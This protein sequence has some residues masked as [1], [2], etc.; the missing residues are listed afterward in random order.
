MRT[1]KKFLLAAA[2]AG[3]MTMGACDVDQTRDGELPDVDVDVEEGQMPAYD[4]DGPEVEIGADQ[5][6]IVVTTPD[7]DVDVPDDDTLGTRY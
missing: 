4:V 3:A 2:I 7:V 6:T 5:D 1:Q